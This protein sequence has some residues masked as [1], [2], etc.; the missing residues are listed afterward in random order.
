[1]EISAYILYNHERYEPLIQ[2]DDAE[3]AHNDDIANRE[4]AIWKN[5]RRLLSG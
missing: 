4:M 1:M 2:L 5:E 3:I